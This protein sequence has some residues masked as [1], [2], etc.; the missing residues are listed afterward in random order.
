MGLDY[1]TA[2][3]DIEADSESVSRIKEKVKSTYSDQVV[4]DI[5][6]F[7]AMYDLAEIK[8]YKDP[9]LVQSI[10]GVGTKIKL[11]PLVGRYDTFG[12]DIVNHS[13]NDIICQGAKPLTFLDYIASYKTNPVI[14]E[15]IVT[16]MV[17]ACSE[18]GH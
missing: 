14:I 16:G 1:K 5:G 13:V 3:V 18:S 11:G 12:E 8:D 4:L 6:S 7:G 9:I 17:R 15:E 2:G 10:D